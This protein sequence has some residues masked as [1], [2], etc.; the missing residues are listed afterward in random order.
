MNKDYAPN[1]PAIHRRYQN[2]FGGLNHTTACGDGEIYDM[3]GIES[4]EYPVL[5]NA[6][7]W[8]KTTRWQHAGRI[9]YDDQSGEHDDIVPEV[10]RVWE[11]DG[12]AISLEKPWVDSG[13]GTIVPYSGNLWC[14]HLAWPVGITDVDFDRNNNA[15]VAAG[16]HL[17]YGS[18][19]QYE[20]ELANP[21]RL[22]LVCMGKYVVSAT[23]SVIR[24][25]CK[26]WFSTLAAATSAITQ[27]QDGDVVA[28]NKV[29]S[30]HNNINDTYGTYTEWLYYVWKNGEGW[31]RTGKRSGPNRAANVAA[32]VVFRDGTLYDAAAEANTMYRADGWNVADM[33]LKPGDTICIRGSG[34]GNNGRFTIREVSSDG[35]E[36]R[37][38]EHVFTNGTES[39]GIVIEMTPPQMDFICTENNRVFG[40]KGDT[41]WASALGDPYN[42]YTYDGLATDAWSVEV[43]ST[44]DFTGCAAYGGDVY[45]FKEECFYRLYN[46]EQD[47][48]KWVL[49]KLDYPGVLDGASGSLATADGSL[50]YLSPKGVMRFAGAVPACIQ[51]PL[52]KPMPVAGVG[53]SDLVNYYCC[54]ATMDPNGIDMWWDQYKFDTRVGAWYKQQVKRKVYDFCWS[55]K[56]MYAVAEIATKN[57]VAW[58]GDDSATYRQDAMIET[59]DMQLN[60]VNRNS[61]LASDMKQTQKV[62][63]CLEN[64]NEVQVWIGWEANESHDG[65]EWTLLRLIPSG[66]KRIEMVVFP[67][68]RNDYCRFR[69]VLKNGEN[70]I[71]NVSFGRLSGSEHR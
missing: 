38:N 33:D 13:N 46:T 42:W 21:D 35:T 40:C 60:T 19:T 14:Y 44:G 27:P 64:A 8:E 10:R 62:Q 34:L 25:D 47:P 56:Q 28:V 52:G 45:F 48:L 17:T 49:V 5:R 32:G 65:L 20:W 23:G 7:E 22:D 2:Q 67:A 26:G 57:V 30:T 39:V 41:I 63:I 50:F 58:M 16:I 68:I 69:F 9:Y 3:Y 6:P 59:G 53:G 4:D 66:P 18:D 55:G 71:W 11:F 51:T 37:F 24:T 36:L 1:T 43:G 29:L 12:L 31:T 61:A 54:L 15:N 70:R